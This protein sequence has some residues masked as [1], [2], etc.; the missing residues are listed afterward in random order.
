MQIATNTT[1]RDAALFNAQKVIDLNPL[2]YRGYQLKHEVLY[3]ARRYDEATAAF[4]IM[5]SKL[6]NAPNMHVRKLR[7]R[8]LSPSEAERIIG[9][10]IRV[11]LDN[12][13]LRVLDTTTGLLCDREAQIRTFKTSSEYNELLL[14]TMKHPDIR[15]KYIEEV[16]GMYFGC[17]M[18]SHRW[19]GKEPLLHEIQDK[20]VYDLDAVGGI[21]KLQVS[22][23]VERYKTNN[24]ELQQ[25]LNSTFV[26]YRHS[27]LTIVYLSDVP[28]QSKAGA[29]A[30]SA[31]N[32]RGWTIGEC[33][34]PKL[35]LFY[36]QD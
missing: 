1:A 7:Q 29:L 23:G 17:V 2:S 30:K 36:R 22:L 21:V 6:E 25:S 12:A 8:Y 31:W 13:P 28:P 16:A 24:A 32:T 27:A 20:V 9:M 5:L 11:R 33:L 4:E 34:A 14:F 19:E 10:E 35:I 26:W 3:G 15:M 18:L